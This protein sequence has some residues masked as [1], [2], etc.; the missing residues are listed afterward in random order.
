MINKKVKN[1]EISKLWYGSRKEG[2]RKN[3]WKTPVS[4]KIDGTPVKMRSQ[5]NEKK[6][7]EV[8]IHAV[9]LWNTKNLFT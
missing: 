9:K 5:V 3:Y 2:K 7:Q 8:M 6:E 1:G 4:V